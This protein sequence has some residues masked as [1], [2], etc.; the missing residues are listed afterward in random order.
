MLFITVPILIKRYNM[1][2]YVKYLWIVPALIYTST[3]PYK[4]TFN[5]LP[6][7]VEFFDTLTGNG[8]YVLFGIGIQELL[9]V[10]GLISNKYRPHAAFISIFTMLGAISTHVYLSEFDIVFVE[11]L[12]VLTTSLVVLYREFDKNLNFVLDH[13]E[14]LEGEV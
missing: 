9:I 11:A 12:V 7:L 4:F 13:L 3:L 1:K 2:K 8:D 10:A 14:D 5:G 6:Y